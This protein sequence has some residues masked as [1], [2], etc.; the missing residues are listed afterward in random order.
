MCRDERAWGRQLMIVPTGRTIALIGIGAPVA[1]L[2]GLLS[3]ALWIAAPLWVAGM[4]A[5]F[6]FD[7]LITPSP[8]GATFTLSAP[9]SVGVGDSFVAR[10]GL[11][12]RRRGWRKGPQAA[13]SVESRLATTGRVDTP[14]KPDEGG[15][16]GEF[17][18]HAA[19]RGTAGIGTGWARWSGRLGL[20]TR[21]G[22]QLFNHAIAVVPSI[23]AVEEE[24]VKLFARDAQ[25]GQR[26]NARLGEGSEFE[27]L[28]R[29]MPG[30]DRRAIDWKQSARHTDLL[31]K[32]FET[33]RD[34]RI[35]LAIDCGRLM[36]D[37][38][39][40]DDGT[41]LSRLDRAA[42]AALTL[43]YVALKLEDRVS[44]F[45]FA[46]KPTVM[47][48]EFSR[49]SD[50]AALRRATAEIGYGEE[51]AN[52]TLGLA[53]IGARLKRRA[54][55]VVFTEFADATS[56]ELM[57]AAAQRLVSKHLLMFVVLADTELDRLATTVPDTADALA[58]AT[59]AADLLRDR[60]LV[61][62]RLRRM[63][64]LVV[65]APAAGVSARLLDAYIR[66]KRRGAI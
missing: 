60:Q 64:A 8:A 15:V 50:F 30:L 21:S 23:R 31:A 2:L 27:S 45:G 54:M 65:E 66:V 12:D 35:V 28:V 63:G 34:N 20:A 7:G 62:A 57:L 56:A 6:L 47:S 58:S 25:I 61:L 16:V 17:A 52:Y 37:P 14:L 9:Q 42:S 38:M 26:L 41:N 40:A 53:S 51:E 13:L 33:E 10:L 18:L 59:I 29:F 39:P 5:L 11:S 3:P 4:L 48:R 49:S 43:G 19:R 1:L 32:Q 46:G 55:I 24:G 44:L 22:K 36:S